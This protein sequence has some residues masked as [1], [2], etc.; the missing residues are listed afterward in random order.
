MEERNVVNDKLKNVVSKKIKTTMVGAVSA[1]EREFGL[2]YNKESNDYT[3]GNNGET[4][5]INE[6]VECIKNIRDDIFDIGNNQLRM[7]N[8]EIDEYFV[9]KPRMYVTQFKVTG[10]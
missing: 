6:L 8:S 3:V 4:I 10:E 9:V 2:T 7:M 1:L 5:G